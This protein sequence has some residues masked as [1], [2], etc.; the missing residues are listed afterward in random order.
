MLDEREH[1][2]SAAE[3]QHADFDENPKQLKVNHGFTSL[4]SVRFSLRSI[5]MA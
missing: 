2:V 3:A 5:R 4:F 1:G